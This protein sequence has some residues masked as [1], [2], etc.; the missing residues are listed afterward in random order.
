[1]TIA[2]NVGKI[3]GLVESPSGAQSESGY[4]RPRGVP[5]ACLCTVSPRGFAM[6]AEIRVLEPTGWFG[7]F[8]GPICLLRF[9][10]LLDQVWIRWLSNRGCSDA[11]A[12]KLKRRTYDI[13]LLRV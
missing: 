13:K 10:S 11:L 4:S 2:E 3:P 1:V 9:L 7:W 6:M 8:L 12:V 5:G